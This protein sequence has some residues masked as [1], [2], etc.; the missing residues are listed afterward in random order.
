M[1]INEACV[2]FFG[3]PEDASAQTV[4]LRRLMINVINIIYLEADALTQTSQH[5][6]FQFPL[7]QVGGVV[8]L[9]WIQW[10][11]A[12]AHATVKVLWRRQSS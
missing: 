4:T 6:V 1:G 7:G 5:T 2:C 11:S 8:F 12:S 9:A 3:P 10:S